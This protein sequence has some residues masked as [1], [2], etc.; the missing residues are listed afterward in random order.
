MIVENQTLKIH[1]KDNIIV[2][3][4][5]ILTGSLIEVEGEIVEV[6]EFIQIKHKFS[7]R[8]ININDTL[9][10][11][12]I[13]VGLATCFIPKGSAITTYNVRHISQE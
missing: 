2:A 1:H 6:K 5:D 4:K 8:D 10:Q 11:Y 3:L 7:Q 9:I 13:P 12:G